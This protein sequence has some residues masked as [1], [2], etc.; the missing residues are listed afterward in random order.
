MLIQNKPKLNVLDLNKPMMQ[1]F[2]ISQEI[3]DTPLSPK[4]QIPMN[5][6]TINLELLYN[7]TL[8][9]WTLLIKTF[10]QI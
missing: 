10:F 9:P 1:V 6:F 4:I 2:G 5:S 3:M 8:M 7:E